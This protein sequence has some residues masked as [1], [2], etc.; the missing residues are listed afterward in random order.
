VSTNVKG[1]NFMSIE[2]MDTYIG[3]KISGAKPMNRQEYNDFRGWQLPG[4]EDGADAGY[5]VQYS[6]GYVSWSPATQFEEAYR[7]TTGMN[8]GLATEAMRKGH[9]VARAGWNGKGMYVFLVP[10]STFTVNRAPLLGIHPAG[11][12]VN[13]HP[14]IDMCTVDGSV[15]PW[16]A[17]Q[18]DMLSDDWCIAK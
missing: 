3:T 17:S 10:G 11:T 9:K 16:L 6:D 15:V 4:D 8:F 7:P 14:H 12:V 5:I 2:G 13:Y 1:N 18:D